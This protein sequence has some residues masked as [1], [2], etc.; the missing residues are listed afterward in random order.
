L[1]VVG[2]M[3]V[4][5]FAKPASKS[6]S[7]WLLQLLERRPRKVAVVA[8]ANKVPRVIWAMMARGEV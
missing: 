7:A 1:L 6:A 8:L 5:R 4:L 3:A 2:A